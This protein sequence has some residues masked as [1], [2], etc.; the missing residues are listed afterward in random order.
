MLLV[1][2][3]QAWVHIDNILIWDRSAHLV[4][5]KVLKIIWLLHEAGFKINMPKSVLVPWLSISYCGLIF[6]TNKT[7]N[8]S[9]DKIATLHQVLDTWDSS[10][11]EKDTEVPWIFGLRTWCLQAI[12]SLGQAHQLLS[13]VALSIQDAVQQAPAG[14]EG[15]HT[16]EG[17]LGL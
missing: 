3:P 2:V 10:K 5:E 17:K 8:F 15:A 9:T 12:I 11:A 7:W 16:Q 6:H 13:T 14:V 4:Q 1:T